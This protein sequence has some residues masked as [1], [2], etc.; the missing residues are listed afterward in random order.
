MSVPTLYVLYNAD[1][2]VLGKLKYSYRK[3]CTSSEENPACAACKSKT[4]GLMARLIGCAGDIT[5]GGLSLNETPAWK[6]AK[7]QIETESGCKVVQWHR[8]EL[9]PE[10]S[11][12]LNETVI[13][14]LALILAAEGIRQGEQRPVSHCGG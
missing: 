13:H 9:S 11:G 2:S 12:L 8:D 7:K 4:E 3:I 6:D 10:V 5:H 14:R 1:A